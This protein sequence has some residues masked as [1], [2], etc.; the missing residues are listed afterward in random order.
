M[1]R[2]IEQAK[3][4][5][6]SLRPIQEDG[7]SDYTFPCP[8][9]GYDRMDNNPVKNALSRR[10]DVYICNQCGTEEALMDM[11]GKEPLPLNQW[12]MVLGF[13]SEEEGGDEQ[14]CRVCGCT[15]NNACEG[16]CYWVEDG[17]CSKCTEKMRK[18]D[19]S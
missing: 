17:L 13:D 12:A 4:L 9:C 1:A 6:E 18:E 14:M 10:A 11:A 15:W 3:E 2:T 16:G 8:R 5:I 19:R 7:T